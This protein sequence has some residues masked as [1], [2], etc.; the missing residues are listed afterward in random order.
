MGKRH[1]AQRRSKP[2][3]RS[4]GASPRSAACFGPAVDFTRTGC[5]GDRR[6]QSGRRAPAGGIGG[7][8]RNRFQNTTRFGGSL[9]R[10]GGGSSRGTRGA[11]G[12]SA[13]ARSNQRDGGFH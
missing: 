3:A 1:R 2:E 11:G 12:I 10:H 4:S 7:P 8:R 9:W 13:I 5:G 6:R